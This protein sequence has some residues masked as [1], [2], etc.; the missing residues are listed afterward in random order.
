M[1]PFYVRNKVGGMIFTNPKNVP[2]GYTGFMSV[3][4][5]VDAKA[6]SHSLVY[7]DPTAL[8]TVGLPILDAFMVDGIWHRHQRGRIMTPTEVI[9]TFKRFTYYKI[10]TTTAIEKSKTKPLTRYDSLIA[11]DISKSKCQ[12]KQA[13]TLVKAW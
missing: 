12:P 9:V 2:E 3:E 6:P 10:V 4:A 11:F 5:W 8:I 13:G 1:K 7:D